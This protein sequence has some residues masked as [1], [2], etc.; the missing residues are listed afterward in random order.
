MHQEDFTPDKSGQ[1]VSIGDRAWAFVPDPLPPD[2]EYSP[3][4]I[5]ALSEA[6]RALGELA[7]LSRTLPNPYLLTRPFLRREAVLSSRI[8]GTQA[9]LVDLYAF[10]AEPP[11]FGSPEQRGMC[12]R[13]RT[14][15]GRWSMVWDGYRIC[16]SP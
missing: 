15:C 7:G 10:E 2:L 9:S 5:R 13:S 6:D 16:R 12:R 11:L 1:L 3:R 4:L 14:T 8:E